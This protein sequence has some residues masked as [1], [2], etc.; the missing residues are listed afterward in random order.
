M[1]QRICPDCATELASIRL[2]DNVGSMG[3]AEGLAYTRS[4]GK[5]NLWSGRFPDMGTIHAWMCSH[6]GR[7][8]LY[9]EA[10]LDKLPMPSSPPALEAGELPIP[11]DAVE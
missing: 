1:R 2:L 8:L 5:R 6:C 7:V 11:S 3:Y 10:E 9:A 4:A